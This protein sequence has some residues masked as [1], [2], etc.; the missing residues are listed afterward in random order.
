[1]L[2]FAAARPLLSTI[3][4]RLLELAKSSRDANDPASYFCQEHPGT[5][6]VGHVLFHGDASDEPKTSDLMVSSDS[7]VL[8]DGKGNVMLEIP[9]E[10]VRSVE[11]GHPT[12]GHDRH[13]PQSE[14]HLFVRYENDEGG[15]ASLEISVGVLDDT[16]LVHHICECLRTRVGL[17]S[18][19]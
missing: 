9:H 12:A 15:D 4:V 1:M 17:E 6:R 11:C 18:A 19:A 8:L 10:R 14:Q 2:S 5:L 16:G 13:L 3:R 7:I